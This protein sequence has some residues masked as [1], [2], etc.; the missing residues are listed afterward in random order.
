MFAAGTARRPRAAFSLLAPLAGSN[1]ALSVACVF[2]PGPLVWS[3]GRPSPKIGAVGRS[4]VAA[5]CCARFCSWSLSVNRPIDRSTHPPEARRIEGE[6]KAGR[7]ERAS[8]GRHTGGR[9]LFAPTRRG[10]GRWRTASTPP[11]SKAAWKRALFFVPAVAARP[12][13]RGRGGSISATSAGD[14]GPR[15]CASNAGEESTAAALGRPR[16]LTR[17]CGSGGG[18]F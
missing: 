15:A 14:E 13:A 5:V 10:G 2:R 16:G 1:D 17:A 7:E 8:K 4:P 3:L 11:R 9:T 18:C 6:R 12:G